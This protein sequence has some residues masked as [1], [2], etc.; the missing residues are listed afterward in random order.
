MIPRFFGI[1]SAALFAIGSLLSIRDAG[2]PP[3]SMSA[4]SAYV[5]RSEPIQARWVAQP[6]EAVI[7]RNGF[8]G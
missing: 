4:A 1:V 7:S 6:A 8:A 2:G 3:S 5:E